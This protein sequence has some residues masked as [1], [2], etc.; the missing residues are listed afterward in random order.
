MTAG[1]VR[2]LLEENRDGHVIYYG[3]PSGQDVDV[4]YFN[5]APG[6]TTRISAE[7]TQGTDASSDGR[8]VGWSTGIDNFIY[9]F[10]PDGDGG[11]NLL[12]GDFD[13]A[14]NG[15]PLVGHLYVYNTSTHTLIVR[16]ARQLKPE[17]LADPAAGYSGSLPPFSDIHGPAMLIAAPMTVRR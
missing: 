12:Y 7:D 17:L 5:T 4:H 15:A 1:D 11:H 3:R 16:A 6:A 9:G 2:M 10:E 13:A 14:W 8:W